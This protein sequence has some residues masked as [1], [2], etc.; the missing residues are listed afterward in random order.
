MKKLQRY[1]VKLDKWTSPIFI[2]AY[3]IENATKRAVYLFPHCDC[4]C[5]EKSFVTKIERL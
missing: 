5:G 2:D 3:T 1:L 4:G